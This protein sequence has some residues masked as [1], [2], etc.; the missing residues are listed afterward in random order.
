MRDKEESTF[1]NIR[2]GGYL[3][4]QCALFVIHYGF[5]K[6]L[7][8]WVLWFPTYTILLVLL[9]VLIVVIISAIASS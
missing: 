5:D 1:G 2:L 3:S 4:T 7:P 8:L 6:T 9:I